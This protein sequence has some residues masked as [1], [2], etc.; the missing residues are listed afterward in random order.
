MVLQ[1]MAHLYVLSLDFCLPVNRMLLVSACTLH[2]VLHMYTPVPTESV[3][4]QLL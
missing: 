4:Q 2:T 1:V 3:L